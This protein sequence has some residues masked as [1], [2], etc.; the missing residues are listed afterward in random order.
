MNSLMLLAEF[1]DTMVE[2][3]GGKDIEWL[4]VQNA[5]A[6][7]LEDGV[8]AIERVLAFATPDNE[9]MG[10]RVN[11]NAVFPLHAKMNEHWLK[12]KPSIK[13]AQ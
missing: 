3:T 8:L 7:T 11:E 12:W 10:E 9:D 13:L 6:V 2:E 5:Q 1:V 4:F